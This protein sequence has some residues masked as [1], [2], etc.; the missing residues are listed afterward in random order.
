[1]CCGGDIHMYFPRRM[2]PTLGFGAAYGTARCGVSVMK[3]GVLRPDLINQNV[4]PVVMAG[5]VGIYG[6]VVSVVISDGCNLHPSAHF[7]I[8]VKPLQSM[9]SAFLQLAAGLAV[10]FAGLA[11]GFALGLVGDAGVSG[12]VQQPKLFMGMVI[13][14]IMAEVL[15]IYGLIIALLLVTKANNDTVWI[16]ILFANLVCLMACIW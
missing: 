4:I 5:I 8:I 1:M 7:L 16:P 2:N 15:A 3:A 13:I 9:Y 14:M 6:M 11:A 10:G 12:R